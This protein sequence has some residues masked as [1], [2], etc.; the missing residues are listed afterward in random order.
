[1]NLRQTFSI[2]PDVAHRE[3]GD[4][5]VLLHLTAAHYY[6]LDEVGTRI[7]QLLVEHG[8][9]QVVF[10][11]MLREYEVEPDQL[12]ADLEE[13]LGELTDQGLVTLE[14]DDAKPDRK[15]AVR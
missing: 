3:M 14:S 8:E 1:M 13:L 4:E 12:Q 9:L 5:S 10:D 11:Q 7:W 2:N 6:G 15:T